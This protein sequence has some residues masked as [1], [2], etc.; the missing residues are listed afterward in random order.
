M[1]SP[2][3]SSGASHAKSP[4]LPSTKLRR[5]FTL[6]SCALLLCL[7]SSQGYSQE[8]DDRDQEME[9]SHPSAESE[10]SLNA[11]NRVKRLTHRRERKR[12]MKRSQN[13]RGLRRLREHLTPPRFIIRNSARLNLTRDQRREIKAL[14]VNASSGQI[15]QNFKMED[16]IK[17]LEQLIKADANQAQLL[18]IASRII[19]L[20]GEIKRQRLST[21][22]KARDILTQ[23][24]RVQALQIKRKRRE[25]G[26]RDRR[27]R[28]G[29]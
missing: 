6:I 26:R 15:D 21:A 16:A 11:Q 5:A 13:H 8:P 23:E 29:K 10:R 2:Q 22:L 28:R 24:Q 12:H 3:N 19:N 9:L 27:E 18:E 7:S 20:E 1:N 17:E 4:H 14:M 25:R